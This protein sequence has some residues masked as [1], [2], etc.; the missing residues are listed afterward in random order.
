MTKGFDCATKLTKTAA[1]LL[2]KEGFDYVGRYLGNSWKTFD[3]AEVE[4]I[5]AAGLKLVSIFEKNSTKLSYFTKSQGIAD[6]EE[7]MKLAKDV[8]QPVGTAIYFTVDY[9]AQ[10]SHMDDIKVYLQ[11]VTETIKDY[12]VGL[13]G[14]HTVMMSVKGLVDYYW[15]TYAWSNGEIADHIHM[16]QHENGVMVAGVQLD[17]ND[18]K[19][20]PGA[21]DEAVVEPVNKPAAVKQT[22]PNNIFKTI[23]S[24][25]NSRY[26]LK[27]AVDGIPGPETKKA[28]LKALQKEL[29]KQFNAHLIVDGE[30]GKKT[31]AACQ[32]VRKG[33]S[34][35][36]TWIIQAMLY[37]LGFDPKGLDGD[38][39]T[40]T[41]NVVLAFQKAH[42]MT[43]DA[44]VGKNTF[45]KFFA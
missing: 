18:I 42:K 38:F 17:R 1:V 15:Q 19:K 9:N 39:G 13:Y 12:K 8:G 44:I 34:G 32:S 37:C 24:T 14:S 43:Q 3:K 5:K 25:I 11:G 35:N 21:W 29:N 2:K 28:L 41:A 40:N 31:M 22:V 23:Q 36:I 7:A 27:I 45:E 20:I 30:W 4:A 33:A 26:G 6:A 16:H 10:P